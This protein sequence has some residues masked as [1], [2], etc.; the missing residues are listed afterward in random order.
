MSKRATSRKKK[1]G[2]LDRAARSVDSLVGLTPE[3][4][5]SLGMKGNR[6][7]R[8]L[9]R[10][11]FAA[12]RV[13]ADTGQS[14]R[15]VGRSPLLWLRLSLQRCFVKRWPVIS[16]PQDRFTWRDTLTGTDQKRIRPAN[17]S[18]TSASAKLQPKAGRMI[19][20]RCVLLLD[21]R[22]WGRRK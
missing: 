1:P 11:G 10:V 22:N 12:G 9:Y 15:R 6:A 2:L 19:H 14:W 5:R 20:G 17:P 13:N 21:E 3:Y 4:K 7:R 16:M 18:L 8:S